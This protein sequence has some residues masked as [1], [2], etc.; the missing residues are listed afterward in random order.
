MMVF[1][2]PMR[3]AQETDLTDFAAGQDAFN[4]L[5]AEFGVLHD[6]G[7][8][9]GLVMGYLTFVSFISAPLQYAYM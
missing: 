6:N 3:A 1:S 7:K 9:K 4:Q 8:D 2:S 5:A